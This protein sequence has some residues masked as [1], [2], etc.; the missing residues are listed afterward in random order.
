[1]IGSNRRPTGEVGWF[2]YWRT[3]ADVVDQTN[4]SHFKLLHK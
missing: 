1:V 4:A 3:G 2:M